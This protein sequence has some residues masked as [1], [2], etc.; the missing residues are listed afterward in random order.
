MFLN[1]G[2]YFPISS[3]FIPLSSLSLIT[4]SSALDKI[5]V[6][7]LLCRDDFWRSCSLRVL[8]IGTVLSRS[9][10]CRP[11]SL[12]ALPARAVDRSLL[13]GVTAPEKQDDRL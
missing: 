3:H 10:D 13:F 12:M 4:S 11:P 9:F 2:K 8:L 6:D 1:V 7:L 5:R